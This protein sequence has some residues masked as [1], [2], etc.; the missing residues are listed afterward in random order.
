[1]EQYSLSIFFP[2]FNEEGNVGKTARRALAV[3]REITPDY[4]VIVV[5]D[6]SRDNTAQI[7][8]AL[9][10]EDPHLRLVRHETNRGYGA[11]LRTGLA[12][13]TKELVFYTDGD[14]QF[15]LGELPG[16]I[17]LIRHADMVCGY[18]LNRR[19]PFIR[20]LNARLWGTLVN[21]LFDLRIRDVDCAF[22]LFRRS[23]F[24]RLELTSEGALIDTEIMVKASRAGFTYVQIGVGHFPRT[25]GRPTGARLGVIARAFRELFSLKAGLGR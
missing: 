22:K 21:L 2:C 9:A 16:L 5:D 20:R 8:A 1:M 3:A 14:G 10:R 12:S 6:G 23:I 7:A 11:A 18:R 4:E 25:S 13:A 17:P 15:D 24:D 19:D